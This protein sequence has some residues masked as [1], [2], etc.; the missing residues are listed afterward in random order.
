MAISG[1]GS[2]PYGGH[3]GAVYTG[4]GLRPGRGHCGH[5]RRRRDD[6]VWDARTGQ[7]Q[8]Q[9]TGHTAAVISVAYAPDGATLATGSHDGFVRIFNAVTGQQQHQLTGHTRGVNA[10]A[11]APDGAHLATGGDIRLSGFGT[12]VTEC[13]L[14]V[15]GLVLPA[16]LGR[17]LLAGVRSDAPANATLSQLP[18]SGVAC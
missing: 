18:S 5:R 11:Y 1:P 2:T 6:A 17:P 14:T 8:H 10:V 12:R 16:G 9:L 7:Q 3:T 4:V 13:K 15:L